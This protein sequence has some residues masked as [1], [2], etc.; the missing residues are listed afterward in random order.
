M[1]RKADCEFGAGNVLPNRPT[2]REERFYI[3]WCR[4]INPIRKVPIPPTL[5]I[6][7]ERN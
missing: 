6:W 2:W 3:I 5:H 7:K 1:K 4:W